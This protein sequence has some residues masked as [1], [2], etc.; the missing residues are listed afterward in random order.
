METKE[1][2]TRRYE[3]LCD[4]AVECLRRGSLGDAEVH[5][6]EALR[7]AKE[8]SEPDLE[9]RAFCNLIAIRQERDRDDGVLPRLRQ[10]LTRNSNADN[11]F[12][13]AYNLARAYE[14][15]KEHKKALFYTRIA[16]ERVRSLPQND[17]EWLAP[18]LNLFGNLLV[19]ESFFAE[20]LLKYREALKLRPPPTLQLR[21]LI[22]QNVGYCY[23]MTGRPRE[24]L[25]Y[26][27]RSLRTLR[28]NPQ[29]V[30][31]IH[32]D[33]ALAHLEIGRHRD[34]LRHGVKA[35]RAARDVE[36]VEETK[37]ALYL[38]GEAAHLGG[39][40]ALARRYFDELQEYF[41]DTPFVSDFLLATDVRQLI[42]LRA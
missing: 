35:L 41:P 37:N 19:V 36:R 4:A 5:Y 18:T 29:M 7:L 16:L 13:A 32:L 28:Q 34:A 38:I 21:A 2:Q 25:D 11:C 39:D 22:I 40:E 33:I 8:L 6:A 24:G 30:P 27:Y 12:L 42:N 15:R 31:Q 26:L 3:S 17:S 1:T 20:A 9:D 23:V 10:I 14:H